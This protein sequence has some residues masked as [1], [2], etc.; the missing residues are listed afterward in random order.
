MPT[1][2]PS[3]LKE[4]NLVGGLGRKGQVSS[5]ALPVDHKMKPHV[6]SNLFLHNKRWVCKMGYVLF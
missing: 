1:Y 6:A 3:V 4:T 2:V 5:L